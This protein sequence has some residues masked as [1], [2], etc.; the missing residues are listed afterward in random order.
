[1]LKVFTLDVAVISKAD[2]AGHLVGLVYV[3]VFTASGG[4]GI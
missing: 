4:C 3:G 2:F 1:M